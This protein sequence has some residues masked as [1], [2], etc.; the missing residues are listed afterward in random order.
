MPIVS[1]DLGYRLSV[2]SALAGDTDAQLDPNASLGKFMSTSA[3]TAGANGLFDDVTGAE[4]AALDVEYRCWFITNTHATLTLTAAKTWLSAE[5]AGGTDVAIGLDPAGVVAGN[6]GTAQAATVAD[7]STA[8][9]GVTFSAPTTEGAALTIGDIA[10]G[11]CQAV[12]AR[13][14][15]NNTAAVNADGA[16]FRVR[17][18]TAA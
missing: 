15:A 14:T 10:P 4:N 12:W 18:D 8:P 16:T 5:V 7:E 13:R 3:F 6:L 2:P 11:G 9:T 17:G 1:A